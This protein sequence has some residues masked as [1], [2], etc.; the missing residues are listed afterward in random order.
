MYFSGFR[1][2]FLSL[3][4]CCGA[5]T[6]PLALLRGPE[7]LFVGQFVGKDPRSQSSEL[8]KFRVEVEPVTLNRKL[9]QQPMLV[10]R[11]EALFGETTESSPPRRLGKKA[12]KFSLLGRLM[13]GEEEL[14][15][16]SF[17]YTKAH[18]GRRDPFEGAQMGLWADRVLENWTKPNFL[19]VDFAR[20]ER[21]QSTGELG[22]SK[23]EWLP[24]RILEG[25]GNIEFQTSNGACVWERDVEREIK[26]RNR[27]EK[28]LKLT[29]EKLL[30]RK[31]ARE[32][33]EK[34]DSQP[35]VDL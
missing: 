20:F 1:F 23:P 10:V 3:A 16:P 25:S 33:R 11:G 8:Y 13:V 19:K 6:L 2:L 21:S 4:A 7:S 17:P 9:D 24:G 15:L 22:D 34:Y 29:E 35:S 27:I 31:K 12:R 18:I 30:N 28:G 32:L 5:T 26:E 14:E